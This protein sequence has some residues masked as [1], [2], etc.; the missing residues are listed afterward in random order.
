LYSSQ[1]IIKVFKSR[2]MRLVGHEAPMVQ[3]RNTCRPVAKPEG[4]KPHRRLTRKWE[5]NNK[6]DLKGTGCEGVAW[7]HLAL[8]R[9]QWR[10]LVN[11]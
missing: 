4:K 5:D 1:S 2:G 7:I 8:D 6:V 9:V 11:L 3:M 10:A